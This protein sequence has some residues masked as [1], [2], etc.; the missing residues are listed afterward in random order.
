MTIKTVYCSPITS[1]NHPE[2]DTEVSMYFMTNKFSIFHVNVN[3]PNQ[4]KLTQLNTFFG[5]MSK[6]QDTILPN[7]MFNL[8][9]FLC[10]VKTFF[11]KVS[12]RKCSLCVLHVS[13]EKCF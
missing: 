8:L 12:R 13:E 5:V 3:E 11:T 1:V 10:T 2:I 7:A 6:F 4:G 9:T